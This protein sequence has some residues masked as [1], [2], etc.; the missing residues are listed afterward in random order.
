MKTQRKITLLFF[1]LLGLL[2]LFF[3]IQFEIRHREETISLQSEEKSDKQI[4]DNVLQIKVK[5][6]LNPTRE[7]A[8]WDN[9]VAFTKSHDTSWANT[10]LRLILSTFDFSYMGVF[11]P[12]GSQISSFTDTA[13]RN[14]FLSKDQIREMFIKKNIIHCFYSFNGT[15]Y[16]LF[17]SSIVPTID[18]SHRTS[19]R[20]YLVSAKKWDN[21]YKKELEKAIG[22]I[23]IIHPSLISIPKNIDNSEEKIFKPI[24]D[25]ADNQVSVIEFSNRNFLSNEFTRFKLILF[26]GTILLFI[27]FIIVFFWTNGMLKRTLKAITLSLSDNSLAPLKKLLEKKNEFGDIARMISQYHTQKGDLIKKIEEKEKADEEILKLSIAVEQSANIIMIT[28]IDGTIEY[29]NKQFS[30]ISGYSK[31]E[32]LGKNLNMLKSG[33]YNDDFY[34]NLWE[35]VFSGK[36]WKGELYNLKKNG[37]H[38][39]TSSNIAPIKNQNGKIN[40][41]IAIDEDI[42]EKKQSESE[43]TEAKEFAEM[44]YNVSP[45]AIFT[46]DANQII[47]SWNSQAEKITGFMASEII[48]KSCH[49]F[50]EKPCEEKC[51]LYDYS[52]LKPIHAKECTIIDKLGKQLFIS[53]NVDLLRNRNGQLIGGIESFENIT[54][55]KKA[56]LALKNSEQRYSSLVNEMPDMMLIHKD[57]KILFVN[58]ATL[59]VLRLP[60]NEVIGSSILDYVIPEYVPIVLNTIRDRKESKGQ[61]NEYEIRIR[62]KLGD[63]RDVLVRADNI[64][65]EDE[66]AVLAILIDITTRKAVENELMK[67]KEAAENAS[68]AKSEFLATMSHEIRTPMNGIIGMTEL[69]L[70]TK[71]SSSQRDYLESVQ[72]SAFMLLETI[73]NILDFSKLEANKLVLENS[74]FHLREIVERTIE[75]LTV[76]AFEKNLE[77]LCDIEPDTPN[78]LIG[79]HLRIRQVLI[80]FI[81]NA[82]KFTDKGEICVS[83]KRIKKNEGSEDTTWIWFSV[84]DTGIGISE[85]NLKN[86][87]E[88]FTQADSSTT[89]KYGGSGLGLSISKKLIEV[90]GGKVF[91]ES[92]P[93]KG[94]VF[95]FEIPLKLAIINDIPTLPAPLKIQKAL[96]VDD[97]AT[98]RRILT[99]ILNYW[100]IE[101]TT[102]E[103]GVK[104]IEFLQKEKNK[105]PGFDV[106]FIDMHMPVMNGLTLAGTIKQDLGL[107]WKPVVIMF[108]SIEKEQILE[109]GKQVGIDYYLTKPVKMKDLLDLLQIKKE[110]ITQSIMNKEDGNSFE[111]G[112]KPGKNILIAE[113]NNINLKLLSVMLTKTGANVITAVDGAK[114]VTQYKENSVDLIFM[115]IHMP[116]LDGF[117]A[118]KLIREAEQGIKHT[119]IIALTAIALAGDREKCLEN[120]MDDYLSKPFLKE[121]LMKILVKYLG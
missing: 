31:E 79:D 56:E 62:T 6:Y 18:T 72:S 98:N 68:R 30:K 111:T 17:G 1:L 4:I 107:S 33:F 7:T 119:P 42:T 95:S 13:S 54:E 67:A 48:G 45:S 64:I 29:V 88:R 114:A 47:T 49:V 117:Q 41:F 66:P 90:M 120:G 78:S 60:L 69:A 59:S 23:I 35:I 39:W 86:V 99:E 2:I 63:E 108:S 19:P 36:E 55:R 38:Y 92:E 93:N 14:F 81:S 104:A 89:R 24:N 115:D 118:T 43:L 116:E 82:I 3:L 94:S 84:K 52:I 76:K 51:G 110:N 87:F 12:T 5:S 15:L 100:G 10:T 28:S 96:V 73:N 80:N 103:D 121:D 71:L 26:T 75:I 57:G 37:E 101:T 105:M 70:T 8:D 11:D 61:M 58:E 25:W 53:K 77:I 44:I 102:V 112:V 9:L 74:E 27:F 34:R 22:F 109:M 106:I 85:Q 97:N 20:G 50:A 113:D 46:V 65:F 32:V 16:E 91:V 40:S 21:K 83:A